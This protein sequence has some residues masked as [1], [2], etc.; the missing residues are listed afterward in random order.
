[1]IFL[2]GFA[3]IKEGQCWIKNLVVLERKGQ[4]EKR[5]IESEDTALSLK[6]KK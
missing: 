3:G 1:M 6:E 2:I 5:E 4:N